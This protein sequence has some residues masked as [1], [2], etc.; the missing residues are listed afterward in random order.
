[1][2]VKKPMG[3]KQEDI[4]NNLVNTQFAGNV[5]QIDTN[6]QMQAQAAINANVGQMQ[7]VQPIQSNQNVQ[8]MFTQEQLNSIIQGRVNPLNQKITDLTNQLAQ[9][10]QIANSYLNELTGFK[11]RDAASK[12]GVPSQFID[13]AVFEANKLAINGKSFEDAIKEYV[14]SN[15]QLFGVSNMGSQAPANTA[16]IGNVATQGSANPAQTIQTQ[17]TVNNTQQAVNN[18]QPNVSN[19]QPNIQVGVTSGQYV[20]NAQQPGA[21]VS[22][23]IVGSTGYSL[24]GNPQTVNNVENDVT[25]FLKTKGVLK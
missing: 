5:Q 24:A 1:M 2:M 14:A 20:Q 21:T 17:Q 8:A 7:N 16:P 19:I 3:V 10:Q 15:Q 23:G 9:S 18:N 22:G 4:M 13:F 25:S 6:Q 11:Q 12:A